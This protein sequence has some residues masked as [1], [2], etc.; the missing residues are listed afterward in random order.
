[1]QR[2]RGIGLSGPQCTAHCAGATP[3]PLS[4]SLIVALLSVLAFPSAAR[5]DYLV[6]TDAGESKQ[7]ELVEK[8]RPAPLLRDP[9][10]R[11]AFR[12]LVLDTHPAPEPNPPFSRP[13][14]RPV[15][16]VIAFGPD[17]S[18]KSER[19]KISAWFVSVNNHM[20]TL[21]DLRT[22]GSNR[23]KL[24]SVPIGSPLYM[25]ALHRVLDPSGDFGL[26]D[27]GPTIRQIDESGLV[28]GIFERL[29]PLAP[30]A[31]G[32]R[33]PRPT[34]GSVRY[35]P[36]F[37]NPAFYREVGSGEHWIQ[38]IAQ[39]RKYPQIYE[40][41]FERATANLLQIYSDLIFVKPDSVRRQEVKERAT[42]MRTH[43]ET[44]WGILYFVLQGAA[45]GTVNHQESVELSEL[46]GRLFR[47]EETAER[48]ALKVRIN[49][50][51]D[52]LSGTRRTYG[53]DSELPTNPSEEAAVVLDFLLRADALFLRFNEKTGFMDPD[54]SDY[55]PP[56]SP[57]PGALP[58]PIPPPVIGSALVAALTELG[59]KP[60]WR[61]MRKTDGVDLLPL[62][63]QVLIRL[64]APE[65]PTNS[66]VRARDT[67]YEA[68]TDFTNP[69]RAEF[70]LSIFNEV[71]WGDVDKARAT[72]ESMFDHLLVG[73]S[74]DTRR[75]ERLRKRFLRD[76]RFVQV[77]ARFVDSD[78]PTEQ[79]IGRAVHDRLQLE[80]DALRQGISTQTVKWLVQ[81]WDTAYGE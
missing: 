5:A 40:P 74:E 34:E 79:A 3:R 47:T 73:L 14:S 29:L 42:N 32:W 13:E 18:D 11:L 57:S 52:Q 43:A 21:M 60:D 54:P 28:P 51:V 62:A 37:N 30:G 2:L 63:R 33:P 12:A 9:S 35:A 19:V 45:P 39:A 25:S 20:D 50:L 64:M 1:M 10:G 53:G 55:P 8:L 38:A 71:G 72:A 80:R 41:G 61:D 6:L 31:P 67:L 49:E 23:D 16:D 81:Q 26:R 76:M 24:L 66:G 7:Q 44:F 69:G 58:T 56:L 15:Y 36:V 77:L 4:W 70:A 59:G 17:G 48:E 46:T 65:A 27:R 78:D 68:L 22:W 75:D